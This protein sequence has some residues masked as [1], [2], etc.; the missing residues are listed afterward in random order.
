MKFKMAEKSLFAILLRSPWWLSLLIVGVFVLASKALLPAPYVVYGVM[1]G[2][3]FLVIAVLA[4][5]RQARAPSATLQAAALARAGALSWREFAA[6]MQQAFERQGYRV[7]RLDG[8]AA[9][10]RLER[11]GQVSLVAC[12][13]WKAARHGVEVLRELDAARQAQGAQ[14]ALYISLGP[15]TDPARRHAQQAGIRLIHGADLAVLMAQA[16]APAS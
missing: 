6:L 15:P 7:T 13:R 14:H 5:W 3:P 11:Q 12:R 8:N 1:G 2:F 16:S 10:L 9:D 4:A